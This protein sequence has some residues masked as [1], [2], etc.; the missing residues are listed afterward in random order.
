[1]H[2]LGITQGFIDRARETAEADGA[3]RVTDVYLVMTPAAE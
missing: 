3:R 2:E 1:V